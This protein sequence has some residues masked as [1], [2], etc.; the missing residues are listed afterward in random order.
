[1]ALFFNLTVI[2]FKS[3]H[4]LPAREGEG[5]RRHCFYIY[6]MEKQQ[7]SFL[8]IN[9]DGIMIQPCFT[10]VVRQPRLHIRSSTRLLKNPNNAQA[11]SQNNEI[12]ASGGGVQTLV[13]FKAPP[14]WRGRVSMCTGVDRATPIHS[15][16]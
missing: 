2:Y 1:M 13:F 10:L 4:V 15:D 16:G 3:G 7:T 12:R 14:C 6:K 9:S 5:Q 11:I 8:P